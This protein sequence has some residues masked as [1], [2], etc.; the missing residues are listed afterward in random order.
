MPYPCGRGLGPTMGRCPQVS[1]SG[2]WGLRRR[3]RRC[4]GHHVL[5]I[6]WQHSSECRPQSGRGSSPTE[7]RLGWT[8][9]QFWGDIPNR[10][11]VR[12]DCRSGVVSDRA[13]NG[14]GS[15]NGRNRSVFRGAPNESSRR[16]PR[17]GVCRTLVP[18]HSPSD[19]G[20]VRH[21]ILIGYTPG[22]TP[23]DTSLCVTLLGTQ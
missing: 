9:H 3:R 5:T 13:R 7:T 4:V 14:S 12:N 2:L 1:R 10:S 8:R 19:V 15:S 6:K 17:R 11:P 18:E 20:E 22:F 21:G 23:P 16:A